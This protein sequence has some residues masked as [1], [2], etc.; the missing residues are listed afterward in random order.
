[1]VKSQN[2]EV[3]IALKLWCL[4]TFV[5]NSLFQTILRSFCFFVFLYRP[6][7]CI[8]SIVLFQRQLLPQSFHRV[9][10][11]DPFSLSK[12]FMPPW[13]AVVCSSHLSEVKWLSS[14]WEIKDVLKKMIIYISRHN[15]MHLFW[16]EMVLIFK[17]F[18]WRTGVYIL[19][20]FQFEN[21][22]QW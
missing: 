6:Y 5:C 19:P 2:Q 1:M 9:A 13:L 7:N 15:I 16:R 18:N 3:G 21:L 20:H 11:G 12:L 8:H 4:S 10:R 14:Y 17:G 22:P